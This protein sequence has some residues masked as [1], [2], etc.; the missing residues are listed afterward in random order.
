MKKNN[1]ALTTKCLFAF[2]TIT[3][4]ILSLLFMNATTSL[5][6]ETDSR[7]VYYATDASGG[8][9]Y[10]DRDRLVYNLDDPDI[11]K[12][13]VVKV[14]DKRVPSPAAQNNERELLVLN[15]IVCA[16]RMYRLLQGDAGYAQIKEPTLYNTIESGSWRDT[17]QGILCTKRRDK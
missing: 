3:A 1:N 8:K 7:W 2:C 17:L 12:N 16:K 15:E 13:A 4:G 11:L 5:G 9:H 14:W 6:D 10:Y